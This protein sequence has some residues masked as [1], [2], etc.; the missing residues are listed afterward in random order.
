MDSSTKN[1]TYSKAG[2]KLVCPGADCGKTSTYKIGEFDHDAW[3][4][5]R[6]K[7]WCA[8]CVSKFHPVYIPSFHPAHAV[9]EERVK[10]EAEKEDID[11]LLEMI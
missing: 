3:V 5:H 2:T 8:E 11:K 7:W 10:A 1:Q 9:A 6:G 4:K